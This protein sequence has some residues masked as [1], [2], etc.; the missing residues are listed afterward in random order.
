MI[1]LQVIFEIKLKMTG[2]IQRQFK[3]THEILTLHFKF[4][5]FDLN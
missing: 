2:K 4:I 5:N 1:K 3:E